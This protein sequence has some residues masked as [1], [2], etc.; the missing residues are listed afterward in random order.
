[1]NN[2]IKVWGFKFGSPD[3]QARTIDEWM[4]YVMNNEPSEEQIRV[5]ENTEDKQ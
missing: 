1:M 4:E 5:Y 3:G 2:N